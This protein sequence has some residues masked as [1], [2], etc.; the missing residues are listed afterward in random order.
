MALRLDSVIVGGELANLRRNSV[1]GALGIRD[2]DRPLHLQLT[3]NFQGEL[4][5]KHFRFEVR[6][7]VNAAGGDEK[8]DLSKLA[9]DQVGPT[10]TMTLV[11]TG[12]SGEPIGPKTRWTLHLEWYSQNGHV[13]VE[14][15][16]PIIEFVDPNTPEELWAEEETGEAVASVAG[17]SGTLPWDDNSPGLDD[18]EED[19]DDDEPEDPYGLFPEDL[20]S[21]FEEEA[22]ATDEAILAPEESEFTQQ[23]ELYDAAVNEGG[24]PIREIFEPPMRIY[25]PEQLDDAQ[26]AAEFHTLLARLAQHGIALDMCEHYTP[27]EAYKL[28]VEKILIEERTYPSLSPRGFVQHYMTHEY[29]PACDAELEE[30]YREYELPGSQNGDDDTPASEDDIPF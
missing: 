21:Q 12:G 14:I 6:D 13:V 2:L 9:W 24:V 19:D 18:D 17:H 20:E 1:H 16:D 27:R 22:L 26:I 11:P 3:G 4:E 5:G 7:T 28:L 29:C 30:K 23:M 8:F 25:K 15:A 10:G